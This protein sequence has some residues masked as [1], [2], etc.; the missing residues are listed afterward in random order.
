MSHCRYLILKVLFLVNCSNFFVSHFIQLAISVKDRGH[1]VCVAAGNDFQKDQIERMGFEFKKI[2]LSRSGKN[3][4]SEISSIFSIY[5]LF[6]DY[7]PDLVH[8]LTIK[9]I[10]YGGFIGRLTNLFKRRQMIASVTGLGSSSMSEKLSGKII[11]NCV[12][13]AYRFVFSSNSIKVIFENSD[14]RSLFIKNRIVNENNSFL[15]NGAGVDINEFCP[16]SI[17]DEKISVILVARYLKDK[18]INEYIKAGRILKESQVDVELLLV[19]SI[20]EENPSSMKQD[21]IDFAN[22]RGYIKDLGYRTDIAKCYQ[23]SHIACLPSYREGLPKSLIEAAACGLPIITTDV[24]GCRQMVGNHLNGLIVPVKN[25]ESLADAI[26]QLVSNRENIIR[27]GMESRKIAENL[28]S[29]E[30]VIDSFHKIY[31]INRIENLQ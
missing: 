13:L 29:Y 28:Y 15:V 4:S 26:K 14:D 23:R 1:R 30:R 21:E 3:L 20:D 7:E 25:A 2:N 27:M 19:G 17:K 5:R 31:D 16:S 8:M 6:S 11:W 22:S 18:G 12:K 24:P 10:L 9:P